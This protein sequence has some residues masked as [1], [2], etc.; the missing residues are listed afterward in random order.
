MPRPHAIDEE[1]ELPSVEAVL[2][3][4]LSLLTCFS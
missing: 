2:A 4:S 1:H 3:G